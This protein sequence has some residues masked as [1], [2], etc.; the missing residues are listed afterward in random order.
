M[1]KDERYYTFIYTRPN[2]KGFS[3]RRVEVSKKK[4]HV[5]ACSLFIAFAA[6]SAFIFQSINPF[7][8]VVE[9]KMAARSAELHY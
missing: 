2:P 9:A 4:L 7:N 8:L 5:F 1:P 3:V 6:S